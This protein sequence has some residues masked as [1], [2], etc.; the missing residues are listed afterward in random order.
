MEMSDVLQLMEDDLRKVELQFDVNLQSEVSLIPTVGRYVLSSGGKRIRPLLLLLSA[1]MCG[2]RGDRTIPLA[3]IVEFIHT[4]TLLHDDVV[5]G[6]DLRRG[7]KSANLI[8]GNEASVLVGDFLFSRSFGLM[9]ADGDLRVLKAMS[10]ATTAMAEGEVLELLKTCDLDVTEEEYLRI[11]VDKTAVLIAAACRIGGILGEVSEDR[12]E[13]LHGFGM[14][15]GIAFQLMDDC[16]DYLGDRE[17]FGKTLGGD[18]GEGKITLPLIH[19]AR[20]CDGEERSFVQSLIEKELLD[21]RDL[22]TT[23]GLIRKYGG[24]EFARQ[25]ARERV[26]A[27]KARLEVF[28][29]NAEREAL[30]V[31][32]DYVVDRSR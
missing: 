19:A 15:V 9:V 28:E 13:A 24:F 17:E 16:L 10:D 6:A 8:W 12:I 27:A 30:A 14:D 2:Y 25:R 23:L 1:R 4:A 18:L 29:P 32:A 7:Q 26:K 20:Q 22:Q 3:S 21:D 5:D 11:V 31:V